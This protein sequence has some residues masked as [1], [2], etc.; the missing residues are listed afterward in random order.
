MPECCYLRAEPR[1]RLG[2]SSGFFTSSALFAAAFFSL[3]GFF[4][5]GCF[6]GR[7]TSFCG[8]CIYFRFLSGFGATVSFYFSAVLSIVSFDPV[9]TIVCLTDCCS[10]A[11]T[12]I[13]CV[14]DIAIAESQSD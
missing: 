10:V 3:C 9:A 2:T 11:F 1:L 6:S 14:A 12:G 4:A 8:C 5:G 13:R 7:C